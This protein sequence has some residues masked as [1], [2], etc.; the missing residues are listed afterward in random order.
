MSKIV[1]G[2]HAGWVVGILVVTMGLPYILGCEGSQAIADSN[3]T[4]GQAIEEGKT[5]MSNQPIIFSEQ[6]TGAQQT[7]TYGIDVPGN[8]EPDMISM[9]ISN[10]GDRTLTDVRLNTDKEFGDFYSLETIFKSAG[11]DK[12]APT[13]ENLKKLMQFYMQSRSVGRSAIAKVIVD[14]PVLQMNIANVGMCCYNNGVAALLAQSLGFQGCGDASSF[15][16]GWHAV[17]G[18]MWDGQLR[19][20]DMHSIQFLTY[21]KGSLTELAPL[22]TVLLSDDRN[23]Y[24]R[25][26]DATGMACGSIMEEDYL[27]AIAKNGYQPILVKPCAP[28]NSYRGTTMRMDLRAGESIEWPI[29]NVSN[30]GLTNTV[31]RKYSMES[32]GGGKWW[33]PKFNDDTPQGD[34]IYEEPQIYGN[35][36]VVYEPDFTSGVWTDGVMSL[37]RI[38]SGNVA[39]GTP[40]LHPDQTGKPAEIIWQLAQPYVSVGA[41]LHGTFT[42][43]TAEDSLKVYV[44]S[45]PGSLKVCSWGEITW[46]EPV[47]EAPVGEKVAID[48]DLDKIVNVSPGPITRRGYWPSQRYWVKVVMQAKDD[49]AN[50]GIDKMRFQTEFAFDLHSR[51]HLEC[52]PNKVTY[53][54]SVPGDF[55]RNVQVEFTCRP[56]TVQPVSVEKSRI[57]VPGIENAMPAD[58]MRFYWVRVAVRDAQGKPI[59]SKQV[60]LTSDR[61]DSDDVVWMPSPTRDHMPN[62]VQFTT[63]ILNHATLKFDDFR[64]EGKP[65]KFGTPELGIDDWNGYICFRVQ[66][67]KPGTSTLT[68]VTKDGQKI[69]QVE[70]HFIEPPK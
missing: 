56:A 23:P 57:E 43:K 25:M 36:K 46:G 51:P 14:D 12:P 6:I 61:P 11:I 13:I 30:Q 67:R 34:D 60:F 49:K 31:N 32:N 18:L 8:A 68:A 2:R 39:A 55:D 58:G 45:D 9:K 10:L 38:G 40:N 66:S 4:P 63:M 28:L 50:V 15:F 35:G 62:G 29:K 54:D 21:R 1:C 37:Y 16:G 64:M 41:T 69:G 47:Y 19:L 44:S 42:R 65:M 20:L 59:P 5:A 70:C 33:R 24:A 27:A 48:L 26:S 3:V 17:S 52:G 22:E 7:F 53:R